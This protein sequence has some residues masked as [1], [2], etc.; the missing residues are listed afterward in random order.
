MSARTPNFEELHANWD[1]LFDALKDD[2]ELVSVVVGT[3]YIDT[4]LG[5]LLRAVLTGKGTAE[6][7]LK[8][9]SGA[10]SSISARNKA[11]YCLGLI[12]SE[13]MENINHISL[14]RN[15]FAHEIE[16]YSF[17]HPE[18]I[19]LFDKLVFPKNLKL[20]LPDTT[21]CDVSDV[22]KWEA[23]VNS[24]DKIKGFHRKVQFRFLANVIC[25]YVKLKA[26]CAKPIDKIS[27]TW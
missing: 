15:L 16:E 8:P 26:L 27:E 18:V 7:I 24:S 20:H 21:D 11:A 3:S 22:V 25:T 14:I 6:S 9:P 5:A 13:C 4:A 19:E 23:Q 10:L 2:S 17:D 1:R 12:S